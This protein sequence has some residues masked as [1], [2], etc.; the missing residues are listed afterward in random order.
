L[1]FLTAQGNYA[2]LSL[3]LKKKEAKMALE[4]NLKK[5]AELRAQAAIEMRAE[6]EGR[7][8]DDDSS[9]AEPE[10]EAEAEA[11]S[12]ADGDNV[13]AGEKRTKSAVFDNEFVRK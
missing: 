1:S 11:V 12:A 9:N 13:R 6:L 5:A 2:R 10:A 8:T 4:K 3:T 7:K